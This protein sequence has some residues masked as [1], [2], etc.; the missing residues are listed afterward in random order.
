MVFHILRRKNK[1]N[2]RERTLKLLELEE[3]E[4]Q[5]EQEEE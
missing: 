2:L 4:E 3:E 5:T 1:V